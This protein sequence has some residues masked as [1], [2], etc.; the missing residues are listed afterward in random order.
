VDAGARRAKIAALALLGLG[1]VFYLLF[2]VG[3]TAGGDISGVQHF[4]PAAILAVLMWVGWRRPRTAGIVLL[5]L[6]VLLV[7]VGVPIFVVGDRPL[8][9]LALVLVLPSVVT[10]LLLVWA[11]RC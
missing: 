2:A 8:L 1:V 4:P 11:G 5:A 7:V 3:E 9:S 6:A 10:G